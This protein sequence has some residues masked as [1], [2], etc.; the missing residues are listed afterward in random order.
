MENNA[1]ITINNLVKHFPVGGDFF[2]ALKDIDLTLNKGE[3][4]GLV[5]PSGSG[6]TTLLNIIGGLDS[7]SEGQVSVLG[8]ALNDTSHGDRALLRREHMGFIFQSYN[9][10]PVYT[11]FE[12]VELPLILNKI[13]PQERDEKVA[14]AIEWVGLSDKRDSRPAM[15]SGGEC[16]RTAIARAIVHQ[17]A[18]VLADEPTANLDA[19]NSHHIMKIMVKLNKE[20]STSFIFATHDEKIMAYLRRIIH[21]DDGQ[22][23]E[24]EKI[25]HPKSGE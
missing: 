10:L 12:N 5:G 23:T 4:T 6:K 20:L 11:V 21:L 3:F 17:P 18:L 22:I 14:Q 16:Q 1:V 8:Q 25:D 13:D 2:T 19:E 15:L 7:P 24:D 9:L